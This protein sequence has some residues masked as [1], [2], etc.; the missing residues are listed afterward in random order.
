MTSH[1]VDQYLVQATLSIARVPLLTMPFIR[2]VLASFRPKALP[3]RLALPGHQHSI[4]WDR[5]RAISTVTLWERTKATNF[6]SNRCVYPELRHVSARALSSTTSVSS[7]QRSPTLNRPF[8]V[9]EK[10]SGEA[11]HY[12]STRGPSPPFKNDPVKQAI[13]NT[14]ISP[15]S[16]I[17]TYP[18]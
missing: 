11:I 7:T 2:S 13:L 17:M 8:Q 15:V 14:M 5:R 18:R 16:N 3:R 10:T 1:P 6:R 4:Q 12:A 9:P